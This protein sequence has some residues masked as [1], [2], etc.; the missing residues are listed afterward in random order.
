M[1][2]IAAIPFNRS[3]SLDVAD[4]GN[5]NAEFSIA[6]HLG[7]IPAG[8]IL[9]KSDKA[10]V[11]YDSGTTWTPTIIYLKCNVANAAI[12]LTVF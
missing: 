11:I 6:I 12:T 1:Q 5:A 2:S 9:T 8:F 3:Q 10:C 4:T 7:R